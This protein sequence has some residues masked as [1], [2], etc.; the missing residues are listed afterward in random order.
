[1]RVIFVEFVEGVAGKASIAPLMSHNLVGLPSS[2]NET[3]CQVKNITL[4]LLTSAS[5][6]MCDLCDV[7]FV[8]E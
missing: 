8:S 3:I 7:N 2:K 5:I 1:M 6:I 4:R